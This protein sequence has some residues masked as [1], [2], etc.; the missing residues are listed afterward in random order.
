M[1]KTFKCITCKKANVFPSPMAS[2]YCDACYGKNLKFKQAEADKAVQASLARTKELE[3]TERLAKICWL[4][5]SLDLLEEK[6]NLEKVLKI[7]NNLREE[8]YANERINKRI[9][10]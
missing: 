1:S 3:E 6:G 7:S 4:R 8:G 10:R 9:L 5:V 2:S